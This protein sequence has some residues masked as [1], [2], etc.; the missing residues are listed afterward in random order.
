MLTTRIY[1]T[2]DEIQE[3]E[4]D[5]QVVADWP[6][7][8]ALS[9]AGLARTV[10]SPSFDPSHFIYA[11]D[12]DRMVGKAEVWWV[13]ELDDGTK[14]AF[15]MFPKTLN[16]YESAREPLID[17][18]T[19]VLRESGA[20]RIQLRGTTMCKGSIEWLRDHGYTADPDRP[21]GFKKYVSYE[22]SKGPL[23][24]P[25][26]NVVE[27]DMEHDRSDIAH[28]ASIWMCS[29]PKSAL[30]SVE[31]LLEEEDAIAQLGVRESGE[32]TA[33]ALVGKNSYRPTTA[34]FFY[35]YARSPR[36]L[37]QLVS[38]AIGLCIERG[39]RDLLVDLINAHRGFEPTYLDMGF[40]DVADHAMFEKVIA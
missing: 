4:F 39:T 10:A 2:G 9:E 12:G 20:S 35:V 30:K 13:Q 17:H 32:I 28:A 1:Q 33:A 5:R 26:R 16:G 19:R 6:W 38:G 37:R 7:P 29:S 24:I 27:L 3:L 14:A 22:L 36:A 34:A 21:R 25:T 8:V 31:R 40:V 18:A 15:V 23:A 11:M